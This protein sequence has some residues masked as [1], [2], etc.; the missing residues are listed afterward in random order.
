MRRLDTLAVGVATALLIF[1]VAGTATAAETVES[2]VKKV[3]AKLYYPQTEGLRTLQA[4][5]Q[6]SLSEVAMV[7]YPVGEM[8]FYWSQPYQAR[9]ALTGVAEGARDAESELSPFAHWFVPMPLE[10]IVKPYTANLTESETSYLIDLKTTDPAASVWA[11]TYTISKETLLPTRWNLSTD[12]ADLNMTIKL[13]RL[14]SGKY[15][16][17]AIAGSPVGMEDVEV[18]FKV[19]HKKVG[20][21]TLGESMTL[22][23]AGGEWFIL[24]LMN[25][26]VNQPIP[27]GTFPE[28]QR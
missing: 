2:L 11:M 3:D 19:T 8:K 21:W 28:A 18:A 12:Q 26:K 20:T 16:P 15:L 17:V 13:E 10:L 4:D 23:V 27:P 22:S 7:Q 9:F 25:H 6:S 5:V 1:P 14:P 24:R